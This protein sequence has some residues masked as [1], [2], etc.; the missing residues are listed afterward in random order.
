LVMIR[1]RDSFLLKL[2]SYW[3][4]C[5]GAQSY[6]KFSAVRYPIGRVAE[7]QSTGTSCLLF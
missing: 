1:L 5:I 2:P 6:R 7:Q 4:P 3:I